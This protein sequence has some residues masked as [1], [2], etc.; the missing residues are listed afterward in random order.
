[1]KILTPQNLSPAIQQISSKKILIGG[2][3]V[4]ETILPLHLGRY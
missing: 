4:I 2:L 1:M 3:E